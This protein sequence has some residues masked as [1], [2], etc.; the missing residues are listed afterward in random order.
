VGRIV[1]H[2][3]AKE[4]AGSCEKLTRGTCIITCMNICRHG[5]CKVNMYPSVTIW[6]TRALLISEDK[7]ISALSAS[8]G[9]T[10]G[11]VCIASRRA[12]SLAS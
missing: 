4:D 6:K 2:K 8:K 12:L 9:T 11:K 10:S 3:D 5:P 7:D 1:V